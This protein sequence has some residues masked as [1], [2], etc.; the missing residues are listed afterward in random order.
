VAEGGSLAAAVRGS[1]ALRAG[2]RLGHW[3]HRRD[4]SPVRV[5][6]Q[7]RG[8]AAGRPVRVEGDIP[9]A[10]GGVHQRRRPSALEA[11]GHAQPGVPGQ[12]QNLY[13]QAHEHDGTQ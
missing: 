7:E 3:P 6:R 8:H 4:S 2:A 9:F 1:R 13:L 5:R 11:Q 12:R 10:M